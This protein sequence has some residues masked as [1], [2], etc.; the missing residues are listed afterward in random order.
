MLLTTMGTMMPGRLAAVL[1][2]P[3]MMPAN[4]GA[5]STRAGLAPPVTAEMFTAGH[6]RQHAIPVRRL[7]VRFNRV[8]AGKIKRDTQSRH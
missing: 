8:R 1:H 5:M 7:H 3:L 6:L 2:M 4:W